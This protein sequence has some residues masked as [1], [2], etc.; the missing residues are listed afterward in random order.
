M[1][2]IDDAVQAYEEAQA[3]LRS[4]RQAAPLEKDIQRVC[5]AWL[6]AAGVAAWR[7]NTG[8]THYTDGS[9][10]AFGGS[11]AGK[12]RRVAFGLR[13]AADITGILPGG[14]RLEI[15]IKR[16]GGRQTADQRAYQEMIERNGGVYLLAHS[17][18]ELQDAMSKLRN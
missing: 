10:P 8:A 4:R 7:Q 15:E 16:A 14:R 3:K 13:G 18:K 12:A 17:L 9:I 5:L 11:V 2:I 1:G 6:K